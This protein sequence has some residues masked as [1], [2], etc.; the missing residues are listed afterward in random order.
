MRREKRG[1]ASS[2]SETHAINELQQAG[3]E[4][5]GAYTGTL[6]LR[7]NELSR[8]VLKSDLR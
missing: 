4:G 2:L 3:E 7:C 1:D 8:Q 5:E 6:P